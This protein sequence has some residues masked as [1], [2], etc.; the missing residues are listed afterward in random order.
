MTFSL[1]YSCV[2]PETP[3]GTVDSS[4]SSPDCVDDPSEVDS[5]PEGAV[6]KVQHECFGSAKGILR[7]KLYTKPSAKCIQCQEC[8]KSF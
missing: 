2:S 1:N 4:S 5:D 7:S 6:L 3:N 8:G